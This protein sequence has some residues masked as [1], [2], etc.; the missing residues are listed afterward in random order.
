MTGGAVLFSTLPPENEESFVVKP[1]T[2][3]THRRPM[4]PQPQPYRPQS[5]SPLQRAPSSQSAGDAFGAGDT[6]GHDSGP[7]TGAQT[8]LPAAW[9]AVSQADG[10]A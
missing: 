4:T 5:S 10:D 3:T 1:L 9:P 8:S 7:A 6:Q 2:V